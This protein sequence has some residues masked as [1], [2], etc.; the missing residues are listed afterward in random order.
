MFG[1]LIFYKFYCFSLKENQQKLRT[2]YESILKQTDAVLDRLDLATVLLI[3]FS[4][5]SSQL[6]SW[7]FEKS[8]KLNALRLRSGDPNNLPNSKNELKILDDE[9]SSRGSELKVI[10]QLA[11]RINI[12]ICNY[13]DE[14]RQKDGMAAHLLP[15]LHRQQIHDTVDRVQVGVLFL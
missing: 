7:I 1:I 11:A 9:I 3:E 2:T 13:I 6:Q 15:Q 8:S 12:E 4:T 10:S 14:L 5:K